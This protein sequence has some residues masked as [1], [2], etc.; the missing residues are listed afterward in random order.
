MKNL[1]CAVI[2]NDD[3][4]FCCKSNTE[5]NKWAFPYS[6]TTHNILFESIEKSLKDAIEGD[7]QI[8]QSIYYTDKPN[9]NV[10]L[11]AS[12]C[13]LNSG[14]ITLVED[15]ASKWI[16]RDEITLLEWESLCLPIAQYLSD[17]LIKKEFHV[18][19]ADSAGTETTIY[20]NKL[21]QIEQIRKFHDIIMAYSKEYQKTGKYALFSMYN[22][23]SQ[24]IAQE[25]F[26]Q[27]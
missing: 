14:A 7:Y 23:F 11:S 10:N 8:E 17:M 6:S 3:K 12:L 26:H 25:T 15:R 27:R 20:T 22:E 16:E 9:R 21:S 13:H 19:K 4:V 18:I 24:K 1:V 2:V 5:P